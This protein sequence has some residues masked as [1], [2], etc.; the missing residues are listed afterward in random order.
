VIAAAPARSV[1]P[2]CHSRPAWTHVEWAS[3]ECK[4]WAGTGIGQP[5]ERFPSGTPYPLAH[6][7]DC[8]GCPHLPAEFAELA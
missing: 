6:G 8:R 2:A 4:T 3:Q 5:T 1:T 7:F